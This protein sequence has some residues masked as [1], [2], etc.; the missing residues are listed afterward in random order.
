[1]SADFVLGFSKLEVMFGRAPSEQVRHP[2]R[3]FVKTGVRFVESTVGA[4]DPHTK[5]VKPTTARSMRTSSLGNNLVAKVEV[6][7]VSG[8][9]PQGTLEGPSP[10]LVAEKAA[11]GSSRVQRWFGPTWP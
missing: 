3:D 8:Q 4:V 11:F 2:Y 7:F 10:A 6:M 1:M 9:A 5:R